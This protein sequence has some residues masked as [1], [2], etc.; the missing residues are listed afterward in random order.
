LDDTKDIKYARKDIILS[1][2]DF[3][4]KKPSGTDEKIL[5]DD[6]GVSS[7]VIKNNY[8]A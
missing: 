5:R 6:A 2:P 4:I 8:R 3:S 1:V 7:G